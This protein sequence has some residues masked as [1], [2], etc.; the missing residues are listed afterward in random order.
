MAA[1][2]VFGPNDKELHFEV[3]IKS[4]IMQKRNRVI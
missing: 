2:P 3:G 1:S 4:W